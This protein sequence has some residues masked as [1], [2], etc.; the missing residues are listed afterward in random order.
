MA[1]TDALVNHPE[2]QNNKAAKRRRC[3]VVVVLVL[4]LLLLGLGLT[5][6]FLLP[7]TPILG[8]IGVKLPLSVPG[9]SL[10]PPVLSIPISLVLAV[11]NANFFAI[12]VVSPSN[13]LG[14]YESAVL[15]KNVTLGSSAPS[16]IVV[17]SRTTNLAIELDGRC[18][19]RQF[20]FVLLIPFFLSASSIRCF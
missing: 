14:L 17:P 16:L 15:G 11:T 7:R 1:E 12:N 20:R 18:V 2:E 9:V 6:Y 3:L 10:V 4:A 5:L 8:F 19:S 13:V